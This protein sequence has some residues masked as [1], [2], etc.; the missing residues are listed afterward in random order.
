LPALP[1]DR[2]RGIGFLDLDRLSLAISGQPC[3][4][5]VGGVEQPGIA[6]FN[7]EQNQFTDGDDAAVAIGSV[8]LN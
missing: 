2:H 6:G 1:G 4:E 7:G 3:G 5:P 8:A